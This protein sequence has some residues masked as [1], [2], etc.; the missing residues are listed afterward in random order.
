M[1]SPP[2]QRRPGEAEDL[3]RATQNPVSDLISLP[4]QN[5]TNFNVGP[6]DKTQNILN[7]QPVYPVSLNDQWNLITRTIVPVVSQ[8][9]FAPGQDRENGL[10]DTTFSA[11]LS[12]ADS[13]K[14]IWGAGMVILFPTATDDR[15]GAD[16][17]GVGPTVVALTTPGPWVIGSLFSNVWSVG[18]SG[19][20]DVNVFTWQYFINYNFPTGTYL[21]SSPVI[22]ANWEADSGNKWTVPF[23]GGVGRIF[24]IGNQ[25]VNASVQGFYNV[26]KPEF[27]AEWTLRAQLQFLFP[28]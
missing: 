8:P 14:W 24:R 17:W 2:I 10:G 1:A 22:T 16:K 28:K 12:P 19:E 25:P 5:N 21:T 11:F 15:L 6:E 27:G 9:G 7:I 18:G 20:Q 4:F 26:E 23:G 3:A 13:G